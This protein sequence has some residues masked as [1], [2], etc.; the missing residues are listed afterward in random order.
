MQVF[1]QLHVKVSKDW[2]KDPK[3]LA[4]LGFIE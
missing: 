1:L 4:K 3:Q 2:Q